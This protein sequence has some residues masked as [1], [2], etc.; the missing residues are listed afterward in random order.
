MNNGRS[1]VLFIGHGSPMNA[2][3]NNEFST[4][5]KELG[6]TLPKPDA[7]LCISAH[8]LTSDTCVTVSRH[9]RTIHDFGGFPRELSDMHYAVPGEPDLADDIIRTLSELEIKEDLEW[10]LDHGSWSVLVHM[11]PDADIPVIQFSLN[12][13]LSAQKHFELGKQLAFLRDKN[14]LILCSGNIIH[15]LRLLDWSKKDDDEFGY[16]WA[17]TVNILIKDL[18]I[19]EKMDDLCNYSKL[20]LD[21]RSAIPTPDH[22]W[23]L[24]YA[25]A[26]KQPNETIRFFNDKIVMGSLSMTSLIIQ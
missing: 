21:V 23:P 1:P 22:F 10:G 11:Y 9:P 20:G 5:W 26:L 4:Q 12:E 16:D 13:N 24:L 25:L 15:N 6:R 3:K 8:W 7:I 2:I 14:V 19:N 17:N 18:I